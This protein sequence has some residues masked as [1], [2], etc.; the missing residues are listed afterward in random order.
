VTPLK[1]TG[2]VLGG[3]AAAFALAC[4]AGYVHYLA[5]KDL[6]DSQGGM[7]AEG[8]SFL[9]VYVLGFAA[10]L[11]TGCGLYFLRPVRRFWNLLS[12]GAWVLVTTGIASAILFW[13]LRS[14][15][16][17]RS[18]LSMASGLSPLRMIVS[19][20]LTVA[21]LVCA[22]F[23]PSKGPRITLVLAAVCEMAAAVP[24]LVWVTISNGF[25]ER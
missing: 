9:F 14:E 18:L 23:A 16:Q 4:I 12:I 11:P 22:M 20:L 19:P 8:E 7:Q 24:W 21:F 6:V 10:L 15:T 17:G 1:K 5:T 25:L 13:T 2:I 3:Y